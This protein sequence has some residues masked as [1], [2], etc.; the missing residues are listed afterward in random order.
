MGVIVQA[1]RHLVQRSLS[2][3][4]NSWRHVAQ[5]MR[6]H[7]HNLVLAVTRWQHSYMSAAFFTWLDWIEE[8]YAKYVLASRRALHIV[9]KG[10]TPSCSV[11]A[12]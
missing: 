5:E 1:L 8:R 9:C 7:G 11:Q 3:A 4:F 10:P 2:A 12:D 6:Q